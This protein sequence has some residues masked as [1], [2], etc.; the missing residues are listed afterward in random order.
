[1]QF[2]FRDLGYA[3]VDGLIVP[4]K[5]MRPGASYVD[6]GVGLI[7][8]EDAIGEGCGPLGPPVP[9]YVPGNIMVNR[10]VVE[11]EGENESNSRRNERIYFR[12]YLDDVSDEED[13]FNDS[14][15]GIF[16]KLRNT[17]QKYGPITYP[18]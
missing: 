15:S 2:V 11:I 10:E 13:D 3:P 8:A 17:A 9:G 7:D 4:G 12:H 14:T 1:M 6:S 18:R 5:L 16:A